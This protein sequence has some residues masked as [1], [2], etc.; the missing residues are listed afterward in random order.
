LRPQDRENRLRVFHDHVF[1]EHHVPVGHISHFH[2]VL[3]SAKLTAIVFDGLDELP[4]LSFVQHWSGV[5][6]GLAQQVGHNR[7]L[8][9]PKLVAQVSRHA[10]AAET[11]IR[12]HFKPSAS[13]VQLI[14]QFC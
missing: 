10:M 13:S 6:R 12:E 7:R 4:Q 14:Q 8:Q 1:V 2:E 5:R 3:G 11:A 9:P